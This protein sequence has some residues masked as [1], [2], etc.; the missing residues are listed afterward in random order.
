MNRK[1]ER[2]V[3]AHDLAPFLISI[4]DLGHAPSSP[5][6]PSTRHIRC[7]AAGLRDV[8]RATENHPNGFEEGGHRNVSR[9]TRNIAPTSRQLIKIF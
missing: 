2:F 9:V 5:A 7:C 6:A 8:W 4:F 3:I 1:E